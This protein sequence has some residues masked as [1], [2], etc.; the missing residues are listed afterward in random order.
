MTQSRGDTYRPTVFSHVY[1]TPPLEH[2]DTSK[3]HH[4]HLLTL[5][6]ILFTPGSGTGCHGF[7]DDVLC[8]QIAKLGRS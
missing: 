4:P 5:A 6:R 7:S 3:E 2:S 1:R 8:Q